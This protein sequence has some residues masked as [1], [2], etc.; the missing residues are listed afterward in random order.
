MQLSKEEIKQEIF[1]PLFCLTASNET[2]DTWKDI[3]LY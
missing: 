2:R 3:Y 1:L